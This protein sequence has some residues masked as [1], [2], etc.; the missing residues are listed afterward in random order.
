MFFSK[1]EKVLKLMKLTAPDGTILKALPD[2]K[3]KKR[4]WVGS[5]PQYIPLYIECRKYGKHE[6]RLH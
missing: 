6:I 1:D 2:S 4:N 5:K 3:K